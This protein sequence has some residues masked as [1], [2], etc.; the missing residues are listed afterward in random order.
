MNV[1]HLSKNVILTLRVQILL[2]LSRV[3]VIGDIQEMEP[4][5]KVNNIFCIEM[6]WIVPA[7]HYF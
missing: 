4:F 5:A 1:L 3:P 6:Q 7:M 2:D